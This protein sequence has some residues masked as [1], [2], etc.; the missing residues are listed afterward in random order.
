M[1]TN[2][3]W[4]VGYVTNS[5][6]PWMRG[7][8]SSYGFF[9]SDLRDHYD[10]TLT[11]LK[12][13]VEARNSAVAEATGALNSSYQGGF[14]VEE[15]L[16]RRAKPLRVLGIGA[17][18]SGPKKKGGGVSSLQKQAD[19]SEMSTKIKEMAKAIE[20][21][22]QR[23]QAL[24]VSANALPAACE[25]LMRVQRGLA[26]KK[27]LPALPEGL[28]EPP[29]AEAEEEAEEEKKARRGSSTRK[30]SGLFSSPLLTAAESKSLEKAEDRRS[31]GSKWAAAR[32]MLRGSK[33]DK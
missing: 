4:H 23:A 15:I 17:D 8:D 9:A 20:A 19:I 33:G 1:R 31:L 27:V 32:G 3:K 25:M 28:M 21:C 29:K 30:R 7:F 13:P 18:G 24:Q 5:Y 12:L 6:T 22:E 14:A 16:E 26:N 10:A 2:S 11:A